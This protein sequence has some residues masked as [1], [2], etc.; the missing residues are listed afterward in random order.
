VFPLGEVVGE[1]VTWPEF[2]VTVIFVSRSFR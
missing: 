2:C 1:R